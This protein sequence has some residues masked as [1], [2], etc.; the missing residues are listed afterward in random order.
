MPYKIRKL[1]N[2][3]KYRVYNSDTGVIHAH[4]TTL[5]NAKSQLR[6]LYMIEKKT[7][8]GSAIQRAIGSNTVQPMDFDTEE[9]IVS[10]ANPINNQ[11]MPEVGNANPTNNQIIPEV[12][13]PYQIQYLIDRKNTLE[14]ET[15]ILRNLLYNLSGQDAARIRLKIQLNNRNIVKINQILDE[16]R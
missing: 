10:N 3:N 4:S 9:I 5:E 1:P 6:L 15:N 16:M 12:I 14:Y 7:G 8:T 11:I 2:K 13:N